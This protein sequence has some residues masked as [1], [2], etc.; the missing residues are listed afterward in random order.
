LRALILGIA[1]IAKREYIDR[2]RTIACDQHVVPGGT[3]SPL[4]DKFLLVRDIDQELQSR[5][6]G[7]AHYGAYLGKTNQDEQQGFWAE[8]CN[9]VIQEINK[10][11]PTHAFLL[12]H[13]V[14]FRNKM[15][16]SMINLNLLKEF[17]PSVV[18]TL[19]EDSYD[20]CKRIEN[21]ERIESTGSRCTFAEALSWRTVE[22]MLGELLSRNIYPDR[23][24]EHLVVARKHP[25]EMVYKLLFE[26]HLLRV[27]TAFPISATRHRTKAVSE[28][29]AFRKQVRDEFTV[30]DPVTIDE[31]PVT[32]TSPL[33]IKRWPMEDLGSPV[34]G[35]HQMR[36]SHF[37]KLK[38]DV[39]RIIEARDFALVNQSDCVVAY[40]PYYG[41]RD[42]PSKGVDRE[43]LE[44]HRADKPVFV[45]H[46]E[47]LDDELTPERKM[48]EPIADA[49]AIK[50]NLKELLTQVRKMADQKKE[51]WIKES[52]PSTFE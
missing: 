1:G 4:A 42:D 37:T 25:P 18:L 15:Y 29:N 22:T 3:K 21:K 46:D 9:E 32:R 12:V 11:N 17:K 40:R 52:L 6:G 34:D 41:G 24:L 38:A 45:V 14:Y 26:R 27:Y 43:M 28:I 20:V 19:I 39:L 7:Y 35:I 23:R 5:K 30:F 31:Y 44:A 2:V 16:R 33:R 36:V 50:P 10:N 47:E 8:V 13:A 51:H 48:F 49:T